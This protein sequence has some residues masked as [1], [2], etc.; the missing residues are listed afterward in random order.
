MGSERYGVMRRC[1]LGHG[2]VVGLR[3]QDHRVVGM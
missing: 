3:V 1:W 2:S